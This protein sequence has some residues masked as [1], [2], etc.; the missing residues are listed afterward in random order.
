MLDREVENCLERAPSRNVEE[1]E[2]FAREDAEV[3]DCLRNPR[4]ELKDISR[5]RRRETTCG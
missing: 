1:T 3:E 4:C 2:V 5:K